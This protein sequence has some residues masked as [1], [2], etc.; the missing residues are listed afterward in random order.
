MKN[1]SITL[2]LL[3]SLMFGTNTYAQSNN[4]TKTV[5]SKRTVKNIHP[6]RTVV[7]VKT[8]KVHPKKKWKKTKQVKKNKRYN[9]HVKS[10]RVRKA[11][12]FHNSKYHVK[13][14][15]YAPRHIVGQRY[16]SLPRSAVRIVR[17]G[18]VEYY[19]ED[20]FFRPIFMRGNTRFVV[21]L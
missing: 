12:R 15:H 19:A 16:S 2:I 6:N 11:R 1:L 8:V 10:R 18:R 14:V 13:H 17:N 5:K 20:A 9:K 4:R 3:S 21:V 7:K